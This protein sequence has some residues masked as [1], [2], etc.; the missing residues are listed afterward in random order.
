MKSSFLRKLLTVIVGNMPDA[1]QRDFIVTENQLRSVEV[2]KFLCCQRLLIAKEEASQLVNVWGDK[3]S[4]GY[5]ASEI[6]KSI[7]ISQG[8]LKKWVQYLDVKEYAAIKTKKLVFTIYIVRFFRAL[9]EYVYILK[10]MM[11]DEKFIYSKNEDISCVSKKIIIIAPTCAGKSTFSKKKKFCDYTLYDALDKSWDRTTVDY[12]EYRL[13]FLRNHPGKVCTVDPFYKIKL[14]DGI[15]IAVV[16]PPK[17]IHLRNYK[18]RRKITGTFSMKAILSWRNDILQYALE[19]KLN[20]FP[21]FE[22][23]L[24]QLS[25]SDE[26]K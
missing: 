5:K 15:L 3:V 20:I 8:E 18:S 22:T 12:E 24:I 10:L 26:K 11:K 9:V 16:M 23:A 14:F 21:D 1:D 7:G 25:R 6:A 2:E 19:N 13:S 17:K 4:E